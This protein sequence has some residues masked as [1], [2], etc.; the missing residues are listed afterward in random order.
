[1]FDAM[2]ERSAEAV[3]CDTSA[4]RRQACPELVEGGHDADTIRDTLAHA[5]V[6]AVIPTK[7]FNRTPIPHDTAKYRWRNLIDRL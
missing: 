2:L 4:T 5:N 7:S 1:V 3:E 6:M